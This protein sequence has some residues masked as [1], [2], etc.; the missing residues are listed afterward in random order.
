MQA[1]LTE[2]CCYN[3]IFPWFL[4]IPALSTYIYV[5]VY[6]YIIYHT[7]IF[8]YYDPTASSSVLAVGTIADLRP[9]ALD[10]LLNVP[11]VLPIGSTS[12]FAFEK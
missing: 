11:L 9:S 1:M 7:G 4:V 8:V 12:C 2:L 5:Q 10:H 3:T 6:N